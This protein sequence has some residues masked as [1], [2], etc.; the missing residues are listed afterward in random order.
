V[1]FARSR[2]PPAPMTS[3]SCRVSPLT[4]QRRL[5]VRNV[6]SREIQNEQW[7][8]SKH[9]KTKHHRPAGRPAGRP[10]FRHWI[11]IVNLTG[12]STT[13]EYHRRLDA[14][15]RSLRSTQ[16][17]VITVTAGNDRLTRTRAININ[18]RKEAVP[19]FARLSRANGTMRVHILAYEG[20]RRDD[21][22]E[23]E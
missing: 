19:V 14:I 5:T 8:N 15:H 9:T 20:S 7:T 13:E 22:N 3:L 6:A 23:N 11:A 16:W 1:L 17:R 21:D 12:R 10:A 4:P 2:R 18:N